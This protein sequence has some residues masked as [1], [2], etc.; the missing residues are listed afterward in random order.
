MWVLPGAEER[1]CIQVEGAPAK[2][3]MLVAQT[4]GRKCRCQLHISFASGLFHVPVATPMFFPRH[5]SQAWLLSW[6][7]SSVSQFSGGS[8]RLLWMGHVLSLVLATGPRL[9]G[10]CYL[11]PFSSY[12]FR[13]RRGWVFWLWEALNFWTLCSCIDFCLRINHYLP[14]S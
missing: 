7:D 3:H 10:F 14:F 5:G 9:N 6:L 12:L 2:L 8:V 4:L 13:V 1:Q 11:K